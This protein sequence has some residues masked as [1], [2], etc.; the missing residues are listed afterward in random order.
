MANNEPTLPDSK[1][2]AREETAKTLAGLSD[3]LRTHLRDVV[4]PYGVNLETQ[5]FYFGSER[6]TESSWEMAGDWIDTD[7][8]PV[9]SRLEVFPSRQV[10]V[11]DELIRREEDSVPDGGLDRDLLRSFGSASKIRSAIR[12]EKDAAEKWLMDHGTED[13]LPSWG[14]DLVQ[15]NRRQREASSH[16]GNTLEWWVA[17]A[18]EYLVVAGKLRTK[19]GVQEQLAD[20]TTIDYWGVPI[21]GTRYR[22]RKLREL[23]LIDDSGPIPIPGRENPRMK[24]N[25]NG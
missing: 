6:P 2:W 24:E 4:D 11:G 5:S 19:Y 3:S 18:D 16:R 15:E 14:S 17:R 21:A 23:G 1:A 22:V 7:E 10:F 8:G 20:D 12:R 9:I 25:K 13:E